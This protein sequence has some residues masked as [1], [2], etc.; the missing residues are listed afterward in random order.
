MTEFDKKIFEVVDYSAL[1]TAVSLDLDKGVY[2]NFP[3]LQNTIK[4]IAHRM[5]IS[6]YMEN[7]GLWPEDIIILYEQAYLTEDQYKKVMF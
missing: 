2:A 5:N 4:R 3:K 7:K 1:L 6:S